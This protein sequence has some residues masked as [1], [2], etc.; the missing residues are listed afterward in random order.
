M[1]K[2]RKNLR[3]YSIV[4]LLFAAV[5]FARLTVSFIFELDNIPTNL[6]ADIT[7]EAFKIVLIV[8]FALSL[9]FLL[10]QIFVGFKGLKMSRTPDSSSSHIVWAMILLVLSVIALVSPVMELVNAE[11]LTRSIITTNIIE[12]CDCL[13][14]VVLFIFFVKYAK[15]VRAA[16]K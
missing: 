12:L 16:A 5:S 2:S 1:D 8:I 7:T 4:V 3:D 13:I 6:P 15:E 10:P 9:L 14:D 11:E